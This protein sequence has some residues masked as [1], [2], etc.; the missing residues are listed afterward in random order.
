MISKPLYYLSTVNKYLGKFGVYEPEE[1]MGADRLEKI[2]KE[3]RSKEYIYI[4]PT[5][6]YIKTNTTIK[7]GPKEPS[8]LELADIFPTARKQIIKNLTADIKQ[9]EDTVIEMRNQEGECHK[10]KSQVPLD[11]KWI[12][13][14]IAENLKDR[15]K[16]IEVSMNKNIFYK[17][18]IQ[19]LSK[20]VEVSVRT[21]KI[22]PQD[23]LRAKAVPLTMFLKINGAGFAKCVFHEDKTASLKVYKNNHWW[24]YSC[25]TGRD[26]VDLVMRQKNITFIEAVRELIRK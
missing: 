16:E 21:D 26:V 19:R 15:T 22:T 1:V 2:W 9:K 8:L 12:Y 3:S 23:I 24:C 20:P 6:K 11:E 25:S 5:A 14:H 10:K 7:E 4:G 17:N 18:S 13:V